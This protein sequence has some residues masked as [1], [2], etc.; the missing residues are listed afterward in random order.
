MEED[1]AGAE[2]LAAGDKVATGRRARR[3]DKG[4]S[5]VFFSSG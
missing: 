3:K 1:R 4:E 2:A 5:Y